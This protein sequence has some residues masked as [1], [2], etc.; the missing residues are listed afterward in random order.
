MCDTQILYQN[1]HFM[2]WK[3]N[4]VFGRCEGLTYVCKWPM[5]GFHQTFT[6]PLQLSVAKKHQ[7]MKY[8]LLK[9]G[10]SQTEESKQQTPMYGVS[11]KLLNLEQ[12]NYAFWLVKSISL[13]LYL[14]VCLFIYLSWDNVGVL[15]YIS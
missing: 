11:F 7:L 10:N 1:Q 8:T 3:L 12:G 9:D 2:H 4:R 15:W 13:F 6:K 14:F 5:T